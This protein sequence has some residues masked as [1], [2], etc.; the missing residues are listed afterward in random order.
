MLVMSSCMSCLLMLSSPLTRLRR[1]FLTVHLVVSGC[2]H[3]AERFHL[4]RHNQVGLWFKLAAGLEEPWCRDGSMRRRLEAMPSVNPQ[5]YA[6]NL[7]CS[8]VFPRVE[9]GA[10]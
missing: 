6:D 4:A 10:A 8:S 1:P 7:N 5:L 9:F 2:L 3:G